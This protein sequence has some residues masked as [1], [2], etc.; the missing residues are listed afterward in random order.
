M[1]KIH[2]YFRMIFELISLTIFVSQF[3]SEMYATLN[4]Q[5]GDSKLMKCMK[6]ICRS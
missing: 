2:F 1:Y 3:N 5:H 6:N 4:H